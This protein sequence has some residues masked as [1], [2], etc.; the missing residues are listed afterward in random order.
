M[1]AGLHI[2]LRGILVLEVAF[3]KVRVHHVVREL[4]ILMF[5][6]NFLLILVSVEKSYFILELEGIL[7][8]RDL[9]QERLPV[10]LLLLLATHYLV[11]VKSDLFSQ[12]IFE[13]VVNAVQLG[14][15]LS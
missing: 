15:I 1:T 10:C 7:L 6:V 14:E 5:G 3:L 4:L 9:F 8:G 11:N 2:L 13:L 12:K